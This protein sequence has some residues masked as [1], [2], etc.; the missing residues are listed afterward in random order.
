M[1]AAG[2]LMLIAL[3]YI[4][5]YPAVEETVGYH[6]RVSAAEIINDAM[7]NELA[8]QEVSYSDLISLS[9]SGAEEVTAIETDMVAVNR[10]QT[11]MTDAIINDLRGMGI[12]SVEVPLGSLIGNEITSGLGPP[13]TLRFFPV[14]SVETELYSQLTG[15]G[16]NQTMHQ[17]MLSVRVE[18]RAG[19]PMY[20][21]RTEA[22]TSYCI[23][24]TVIVGGIP[25]TYVEIGGNALVA[26]ITEEAG[27]YSRG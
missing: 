17:I 2:L 9:R 26:P 7:Q 18:I 25:D 11:H 6:A 21:I 14:G 23:A 20:D 5:L 1:V 10:L 27:Q 22:S 8:R 24:Q 3:V 13:V 16:I 12:K 15:A 19:I 4:Q